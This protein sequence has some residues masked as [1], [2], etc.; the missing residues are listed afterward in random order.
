MLSV[1]KFEEVARNRYLVTFCNV[2]CNNIIYTQ[3]VIWQESS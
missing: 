1:L 2:Y 3:L